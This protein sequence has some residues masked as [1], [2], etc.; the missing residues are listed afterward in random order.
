MTFVVAF[1]WGLALV[2]F[3]GSAQA[4]MAKS[5]SFEGVFAWSSY[6]E[7]TEIVNG[8]SYWHGGF[9]GAFVNS[10]SSGFLHHAAGTCPAGGATVGGRQFFQGSC[11]LTDADGDQAM[12]VWNCE[13]QADG[14]CPGPQTWVAGTGKYE[15]ISG[16]M[17]FE[18]RFIGGTTQ[19]V[20]DW[21]GDWNLP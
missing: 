7:T 20:S 4:Q 12:F 6:G 3:A 8:S 15:G 21:K 16:E 2:M 13:M 19:G 18:G 9:N 14:V 11:V 5:G 1:A 17:T 10:A